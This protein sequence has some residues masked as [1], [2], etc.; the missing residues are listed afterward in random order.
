MVLCE[1]LAS[2]PMTNLVMSMVGWAWLLPRYVLYVM[3][4]VLF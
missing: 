4:A 1:F 3:F 2:M